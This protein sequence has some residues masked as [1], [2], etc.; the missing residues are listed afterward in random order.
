MKVHISTVGYYDVHY[1]DGQTIKVD[2]RDLEPCL[3]QR[4]VART[5]GYQPMLLR[6]EIVQEHA[7][8]SAVVWSEN[9]PKPKNSTAA[10]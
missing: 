10:C 1:R 9:D 7:L 8:P 3:S 6:K 5:P 2:P 4:K